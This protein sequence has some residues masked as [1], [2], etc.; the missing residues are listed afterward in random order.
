MND[1]ILMHNKMIRKKK[2]Y[3]R[4]PPN[5]GDY[6]KMRRGFSWNT[7]LKDIEWFP[8]RKMNAAHVAVD[9]QANSWRKNKI[10]MYYESVTGSKRYT[11][12]DLSK[13]SNKF[14]NVLKKY[15]GRNLTKQLQLYFRESPNCLRCIL[16]YNYFGEHNFL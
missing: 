9:E 12:L 14:A 13:L 1:Q 4:K 10:A 2:S 16:N 3:F 7:V 5:F 8:N 6:E 15:G 11:Y